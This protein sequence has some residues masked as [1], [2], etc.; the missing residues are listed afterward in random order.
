MKIVC[1]YYSS[2]LRAGDSSIY[3]L[4]SQYLIN[5]DELKKF[6]SD[7]SKS[8]E[9]FRFKCAFYLSGSIAHNFAEI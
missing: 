1:F 4:H 5:K 2:G 3:Q 8:D 7:R 6:V 9:S